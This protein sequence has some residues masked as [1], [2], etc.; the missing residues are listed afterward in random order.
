MKWNINSFVEIGLIM[1]VLSGLT[2][3]TVD[4]FSL[5][6]A[7]SRDVERKSELHEVSKVVRLYY[8]DYKKLPTDELINSLWGKEWRDGDYVYMKMIPKEDYGLK[9][10]CY[11]INENGDGFW[12]FT[13]LE[14]KFDVDCIKKKWKCQGQEYCY[15]DEYKNSDI[16]N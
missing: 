9:E 10:Y 4:Q 11:Q 2:W 13:D 6:K 7:K 3:I 5:A 12:L 1:V 8:K 16:I 14:N 15:R